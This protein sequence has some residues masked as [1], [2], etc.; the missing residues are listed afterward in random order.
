MTFG[1][2][3]CSRWTLPSEGDTCKG[4]TG[5][6]SCFTSILFLLLKVYVPCVEGEGHTGDGV[7]ILGN[8]FR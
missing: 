8:H 4:I 6:V 5:T 1:Q 7:G 3:I 2:D